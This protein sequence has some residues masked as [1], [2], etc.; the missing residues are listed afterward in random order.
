MTTVLKILESLDTD[1][2]LEVSKL[3][4]TLKI[5]K[6]IDRENLG[7]AINALTK[8]GIIQNINDEV[9]DFIIINEKDFGYKNFI[10]LIGIDSPGLTSSMAIAKYVKDLIRI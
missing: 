7:I 9:Q 4:K 3:E 2:G 6:K 5:N 8:L 10:N 1:E